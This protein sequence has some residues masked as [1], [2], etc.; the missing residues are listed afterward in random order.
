MTRT[1]NVQIKFREEG[2][3]DT[4]TVLIQIVFAPGEI[5]TKNLS[6]PNGGDWAD[7]VS[8]DISDTTPLPDPLGDSGSDKVDT[9]VGVNISPIQIVPQEVDKRSSN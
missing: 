3:S 6:V 8:V 9:D 2:E 4:T 1:F 5:Y 7:V